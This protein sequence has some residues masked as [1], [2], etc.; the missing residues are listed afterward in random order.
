MNAFSFRDILKQNPI[1]LPKAALC[2][3]QEIAYP[4]L[5][6]RGYLAQL[7]SMAET[8]VQLFQPDDSTITRAEVIADYLFKQ[9]GLSGNKQKYDDPRNS[10]LNEVLDRKTGIP[11][12]LAI[13][14]L[15]V[16]QKAG[17]DAYGVGLPGHF[18]VGVREEGVAHYWD[19]F[20]GGGRLS[21]ADCARL[22]EET[23]G[24]QGILPNMWFAPSPPASILGRMLNNLRLLYMNDKQWPQALK[25][26]QLLY[27]LNPR[28]DE[29]LRDMGLL[30]FYND[31]T[32]LTA[33]YLESYL[34]KRPKAKDAEKIFQ[35][36]TSLGQTLKWLN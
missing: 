28:S 19:P 15:A 31:N 4:E 1:D 5:N 24:Y 29:L 2:L 11:I 33:Y 36:L 7:E 26:T 25:A 17:I 14:Y 27:S 10:F 22:V 35:F 34:A 6:V 3:A 20:H 30:C 21:M 8:A 18:I 23:T 12:S 16:C 32:H 13:I 9:Y